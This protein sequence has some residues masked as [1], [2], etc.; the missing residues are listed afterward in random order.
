MKL[1]L[2]VCVCCL[3][4]V[5]SLL[6]T[7]MNQHLL[8]PNVNPK[9]RKLL[10][11]EDTTLVENASMVFVIHVLNV[12]CIQENIQLVEDI[13]NEMNNV[14]ECNTCAMSLGATCKSENELMELVMVTFPGFTEFDFLQRLV[15]TAIVAPECLLSPLME[16][17]GDVEITLLQE[18]KFIIPSK[19]TPAVLVPLIEGCTL[20]G[21]DASQTQEIMLKQA[22]LPQAPEIEVIFLGHQPSV[23]SLDSNTD[24]LI[25]SVPEIEVMLIGQQPSLESLDDSN[26]DDLTEL[27][28]LEDSPTSENQSIFVQVPQQEVALTGSE[29]Q[30]ESLDSN[31]NDFEL[32]VPSEEELASVNE[33]IEQIDESRNFKFQQFGESDIDYIESDI[34]DEI[35][36]IDIQD[37]IFD[38]PYQE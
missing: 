22:V 1:W 38:S 25:E 7:T 34:L 10:Q 5:I 36:N 9:Q 13:L 20:P 35:D 11:D 32:S 6:V 14:A 17:V 3:G 31:M 19:A 21:T 30:I 15:N 12:A 2:F 23:E 28:P 8:H 18:G 37:E 24:D 4:Q 29:P 33:A 16:Q 27:I 26:M